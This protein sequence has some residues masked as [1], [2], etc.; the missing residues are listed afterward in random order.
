MYPYLAVFVAKALT[1]NWFWFCSMTIALGSRSTY[2]ILPF[3][4]REQ[5]AFIITEVHFTER[6]RH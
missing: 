2:S 1:L 3:P 4:S 6:N 5:T